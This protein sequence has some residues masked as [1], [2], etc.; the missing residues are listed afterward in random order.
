MAESLVI[1]ALITSCLALAVVSWLAR[2]VARLAGF[3]FGAMNWLLHGLGFLVT[4]PFVL[5]LMV[6]TNGL[7]RETWL[8]GGAIL[9]AA[10][11]SFIG[12]GVNLLLD[13]MRGGS[14]AV[15]P[16]GFARR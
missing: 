16:R 4:L 9:A 8:I 3:P 5:T 1:G 2:L 11:I 13:V 10:L 6:L 15:R 14:H 7:G 12:G